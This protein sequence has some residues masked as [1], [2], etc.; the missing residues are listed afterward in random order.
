MEDWQSEKCEVTLL[1][2][3]PVDFIVRKLDEA[4]TWLRDTKIPTQWVDA[5]ADRLAL[6]K[7]CVSRISFLTS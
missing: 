7:V 5:L 6:R 3:V 4:Y 1:E 2:G